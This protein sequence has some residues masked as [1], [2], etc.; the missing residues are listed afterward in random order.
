MRGNL[1]RRKALL[2]WVEKRQTPNISLTCTSNFFQII[3]Y[4]NRYESRLLFHFFILDN[5]FGGPKP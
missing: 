5:G 2:C 1:E 4:F 3:L